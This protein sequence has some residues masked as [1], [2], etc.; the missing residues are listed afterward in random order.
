MFFS[1]AE[2][3]LLYNDENTSRYMTVQLILIA[4][5][6][7]DTAQTC[8]PG[9]T[10]PTRLDEPLSVA[11]RPRR[12]LSAIESVT[13]EPPRSRRASVLAINWTEDAAICISSPLRRRAGV[14]AVGRLSI[15]WI[16]KLRQKATLVFLA[17]GARHTLLLMQGAF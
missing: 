15:G 4:A 14:A 9:I 1:L 6:T 17:Y 3:V 16:L 12:V 5:T 10:P 7:A 11:G 2:R 13:A 8:P